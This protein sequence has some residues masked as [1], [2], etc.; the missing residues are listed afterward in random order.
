MSDFSQSSTDMPTHMT[1]LWLVSQDTNPFRTGYP[2]LDLSRHL[3]ITPF[4]T[5][6]YELHSG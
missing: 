1:F 4:G 2:E 6:Q 5:S 3:V